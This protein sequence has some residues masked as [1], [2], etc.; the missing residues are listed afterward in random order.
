MRGRLPL[1]VR[2]SAPR[3]GGEPRYVNEAQ[4]QEP[5]EPQWRAEAE[6]AGRQE[7]GPSVDGG[8]PRNLIRRLPGQPVSVCSSRTGGRGA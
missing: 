7:P 5:P 6:A 2:E 3:G 8:N 4:G 1:S